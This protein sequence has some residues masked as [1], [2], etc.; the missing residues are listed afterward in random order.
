MTTPAIAHRQRIERNIVTLIV[1]NAISKGYSISGFDEEEDVFQRETDPAEI[2][3]NVMHVDAET[4]IF[5]RPDGTYA[6]FVFLVYGN[7]GYDAI[8][9]HTATDEIADILNRAVIYAN[10]AEDQAFDERIAKREAEA[11]P[12]DDPMDDFNYV[13]SRHHY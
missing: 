12:S 10:T 11:K 7:D 3:K 4:L 2:M 6:G 1:E 9:D 8:N 5:H 13:G